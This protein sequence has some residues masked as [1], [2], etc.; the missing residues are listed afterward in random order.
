MTSATAALG[1][2]LSVWAHPDDEV[3]VVVTVR[4]LWSRLTSNLDQHAAR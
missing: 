3:S 1:T 4:R 2:I